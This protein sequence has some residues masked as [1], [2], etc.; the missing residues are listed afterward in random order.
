VCVFFDVF[1]ITVSHHFPL[2]VLDFYERIVRSKSVGVD[3]QRFLLAVA[4]E[5]SDG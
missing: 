2:E 4:E 5:E 3:C 1:A